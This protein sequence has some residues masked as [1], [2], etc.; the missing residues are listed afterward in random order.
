MNKDYY[1]LNDKARQFLKKDYLEK[2]VEPEDRI[3]QISIAAEKILK[4]DGFAE[5]FESYM[6]KGW[7]SLSSPIWSNFGLDRGLPISCITG[8]NWINTV[9]GGK[10]ASDVK[11]GD[12]LLTHKG[13]FRPVTNIIITEDRSD[14][15]KIKIGNRNTPI[16][17]TGD[18]RILT[19]TGWKR[20]DELNPD[21]D[22]VAINGQ[23]K[24]AEENY[25]IDLTQYC[26]YAFKIEDNLIKKPLTLKNQN[27]L[28]KKY[29][30][31]YSEPC[32]KVV[33]DEELAWAIGLWFA[34]GSL[35][36]STSGPNGIRITMSIKEKDI[37]EKWL[38][39]IKRKFNVGG[40]T[41]EAGRNNVKTWINANV[42]SVVLGRFFESFGD[43]CLIKIL[44]D[45]LLRLPKNLCKK[46]LEGLILGDGGF[47]RN[48]SV[49]L[50]LSNPKLIMQA[51]L[52]GLKTNQEM[53][54]QMQ[55]KPSIYN[56]TKY[57]YTISF[58]N[59]S[60]SRSRNSSS[61][62]IKF[63]DGLIYSPIKSIEKTDLIDR[64]YDFEV[65]ED[66]S[67]SVSGVIVH[68]CNGSYVEDST[69][70]ILNKAAEI[71]IMTKYGAGTSAYIGDLRG[72]GAAIRT[73]GESSGPVH[74]AEIYNCVT[75]VI[76]Q[77][78]IRR[79]SCAVYLD[80]EHPDIEEFL[81]IRSEGHP[82]QNLSIGV[83][84]SDAWM[85]A[86]QDGDSNKRKIWAKII[87]KRFE[88]G[89]PYLFFTDT[90]NKNAPKVY[91][92]K[93]LKIHASNL[94]TEIALHS[95]KNESFVCNLMSQNLQH[96]DEWKDTDA[97]QTAIFFLDAIQSEY[98][99]KTKNLRFMEAAHNF[100]KTQRALGLGVLG[101]HSLLQ[102]KSIPFESMQAKRLNAE[103]FSNIQLNA[104]IATA[105]LAET[106]GE[107]ELL[108]GYGER[109]VTTMA[110]A[111]TTSSAFIL[112]QSSNGVEPYNS[113]YY[114]QDLAKGKFTF[115]NPFLKDVLKKYE[116][117]TAEVW[118]SILVKGGSVQHLDFLSEHE[119]SVFKT[120]GEISQ[121]E[122]IIQ[123][124]QRQKYIDQA[125][126]INV[127]IHANTPAKDV[128]QLYIK[129]WELGVKSLYY[130]RGTNPAQELGR[131]LLSC[132]SCE[133]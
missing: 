122:I 11:I 17:I 74:F 30:D 85:K 80:V 2:G 127:M 64:V 86:L 77:S 44:P 38:E 97:T 40:N 109:N 35:S 105:K 26:N 102:S 61:A 56:K 133:A 39:I 52:L 104:K 20:I 126:S 114:V 82:I 34:E 63:H 46:L 93:G 12:L 60:N 78:S 16:K 23:I 37:V 124:A 73:G 42:N 116:K 72:R 128:S 15:W 8:D 103:I 32:A 48:D 43:G 50:T 27:K 99:E 110:I 66:H 68:N 41:H 107:P 22:L 119:K 129:A 113:N 36:K 121:M 95:S 123:A 4:I 57:V 111:P 51:Y 28:N 106:L 84:I 132:A 62:G 118:E 9:D 7:Y 21:L 14:I 54:L 59:Y 125:Q 45:F 19:N 98:I 94:C 3:K 10:L 5:K 108:K 101:W 29:C 92:D 70:E 49:R 33:I 131:N 6:A 71:G 87:K 88:T 18:H 100:A 13:N 25:T 1:W 55:E 79:G 90:V 53:S 112:G 96:W 130:Q 76:S 65:A 24:Y 115:K 117:D 89:Y 69:V 75:N 91:K 47:K 81:R 31:Y 83:C 120:F 58:R 67:F